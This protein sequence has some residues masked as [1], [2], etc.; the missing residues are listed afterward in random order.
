MTCVVFVSYA[1]YG[2]PYLPTGLYSVA[3]SSYLRQGGY[4]IVVVCL[5]VCWQLFTK[6]S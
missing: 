4:V 2:T 6:T 1:A 3:Y 5:S